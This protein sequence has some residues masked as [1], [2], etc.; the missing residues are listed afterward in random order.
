MKTI[1]SR[2]SNVGLA[3]LK[4]QTRAFSSG[5]HNFHTSSKVDTSKSADAN[6]KAAKSGDNLQLSALEKLNA[7][8]AS[9]NTQQSGK[10]GA[11]AVKQ[12]EKSSI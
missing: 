8:I 5:N 2:I 9:I 12:P 3:G 1:V 7:T 11:N 10:A 4:A 6:T